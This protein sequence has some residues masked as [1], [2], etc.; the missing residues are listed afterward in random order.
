MHNLKRTIVYSSLV[1]I[2]LFSLVMVSA[3]DLI[4]KQLKLD[5]EKQDN[6]KFEMNGGLFIPDLE[7]ID[8]ESITVVWP[9]EGYYYVMDSLQ[10]EIQTESSTNC[11][12]R[13]DESELI[14]M[15]ETGGTQHH[16]TLYD[17]ADNM[18]NEQPYII[19]FICNTGEDASTYFWINT[20]EF[21]TYLIRQDL[22][23]WEYIAAWTLGS[24]EAQNLVEFYQ[25][26]YGKDQDGI[27]THADVLVFN[28]ENSALSFLN[29]QILNDMDETVKVIEGNNVYFSEGGK[30]SQ[31]ALWINGNKFIHLITYITGNSVSTEAEVSS[32]I[33]FA[34]LHKYPSE[35]RFGFCGDGK[36]DLLNLNGKTEECDTNSQF[37][38]CSIEGEA[39]SAHSERTCS[40]SCKWEEWGECSAV[41]S[42]EEICDNIDN[43]CDGEI[44]EE[45]VCASGNDTLE[46]FIYSPFEEIFSTSKVQLNISTGNTTVN[47]ISCID[48]L[49]NDRE[50][51]LCNNCNAYGF[52]QKKIRSFSQGEHTLTIKAVKNT[53]VI[54]QNISFFIDSKKPKVIK[55]GP[56]PNSFSS[57]L[58][59]FVKYT[60]ENVD[61]VSLEFNESNMSF[62]HSCPS[63]KNKECGFDVDVSDFDGEELTFWFDIEDIA[64]NEVS[65]KKSKIKVDVTLPVIDSVDF[66]I[67]GNSILMI[68]NVIEENFD[69]ISYIDMHD[70][71]LREI[72]FCSRLKN[73]ACKVKKSFGAGEHDLILRVV[74][75]AGNAIGANLEFSV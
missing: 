55:T 32:E 4:S 28:D 29:D 25:G 50:I 43:D 31:T 60:E 74:D 46:L 49:N 3:T 42:T 19:D 63:G 64:G 34:Y 21:D 71:N 59:F 30:S 7:G 62:S 58:N 72:I 48:W 52:S 18:A 75:K 6:I 22:G 65:S 11:S 20:T 70:P 33:L 1:L 53:S 17:L 2:L 67:T 54:E 73:G 41:G 61:R 38:A 27:Y 35:V 12:Y 66:N 13:L 51:T 69:E 10:L 45:N 47:K 16:H 15:E 26:S 36:I 44:D 8:S 68:V 9:E 23:S 57:G 37:M 40:T 14:T 56:K 24:N 39:C 5:K